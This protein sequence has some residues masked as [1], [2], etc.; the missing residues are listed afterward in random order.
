MSRHPWVLHWQTGGQA[1]IVHTDGARATL[2]SSREAA[3]GTPLRA[4]VSTDDATVVCEKD[5][6][7]K[8]KSCRRLDPEQVELVGKWVNLSKSG[9][10]AMLAAASSVTRE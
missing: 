3:Q 1:R 4:T 10:G 6:Q 5:I 8:V 2:V 7:F 9:R